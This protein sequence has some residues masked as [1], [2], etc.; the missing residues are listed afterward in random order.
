MDI[1]EFSINTP[2]TEEQIEV[3]QRIK[4]NIKR[5]ENEYALYFVECNLPN[6]RR[7]LIGEL[8][9]TNNLNLLTLDI[10]NYPK[11]EGLHI[12]EWVNKQKNKYQN[13]ESKQSLDA[14]NII[15]LEQLLPT[16]SDEQIIKTVSEL[17]W[18]R[19]YFQA[20]KVPIIFWL[21]SYALALLA[22][23]ASD[24]YDWYSDIYHFDSNLD[25]KKLAA[26]D[27][28]SSLKHPDSQILSQHYQT[29]VEKE[30]QL[31]SLRALLDEA[32]T[33][34]DQAYVRTLMADLFFS[35]G[36]L[37]EALMHWKDA[38]KIV[39]QID[40][41]VAEQTILSNISQIYQAQGNYNKA[42]DCL[43]K[44]QSLGEELNGVS[45]NGAIS[46]NISLV[47]IARGDYKNALKELENSLKIDAKAN[48]DIALSTRYINTGGIYYKIGEYD[49]AL[50]YMNRALKL[51]QDIGNRVGI[52][53]SYNGIATIYGDKGYKD[54][55]LQY[56]KKSLKI[57]EEV[58]NKVLLSTVL[59]NISII[60]CDQRKFDASLQ[61]LNRSLAISREIGDT[62][63]VAVT[64]S[65]IDSIEKLIN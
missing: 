37:D 26:F 13:A 65:T 30:A 57:C 20:L 41:K 11:N 58:G 18:R 1:L 4:R 16:G 10:A 46:N 15:G 51:S 53:H 49:K 61:Y 8:D 50:D 25:Q 56:L 29:S 34:N 63:N 23:Q 19:S 47:Y 17:N 21:P 32:T 44:A 27:Q 31:K 59:Y 3:L 22:N 45:D 52:S 48:D 36:N 43:M 38:M 62:E 28:Y 2:I 24:F 6:L 5:S 64:L 54:L 35:I 60:Y 39:I 42:L 7:Q 12:D 9:N 33:L 14:I 40:N 55:A